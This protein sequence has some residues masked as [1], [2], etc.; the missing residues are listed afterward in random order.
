MK[1]HKKKQKRNIRVEKTASASIAIGDIKK[2][3]DT[4][5]LTYGQFSL[6]DALIVILHQTG[7]ADVVI[8]TWTA[9][10]AHLDK[11]KELM[12]DA[13]IR[14]LKLI[15]DRS[16][17]TRQPAYFKQM[18]DTFGEESIRETVTHAKFMIITNDNWNIVVRTSMNLNENPRLE[19]IEISESEE[20]TA[21][22]QTLT[23]EMFRE[24][25]PMEK[26]NTLPKLENIENSTPFKLVEAKRLK[27]SELKEAN[28]ETTLSR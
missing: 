18:I 12:T 8:S 22:F 3:E 21:F 7:E 20:F 11:A 10:H 17:K 1:I 23:E 26:Q 2:G 15:V 9:A 13:N 27:I 14:S 4:F 28:Y 19:N 24:I 16:F 25:K 5:I 6:I